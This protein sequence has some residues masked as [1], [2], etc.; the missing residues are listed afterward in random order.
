MK[1]LRKKYAAEQNKLKNGQKLEITNALYIGNI[2]FTK[3]KS[4][5]LI[6]A[7]GYI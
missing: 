7:K 6:V 4:N 1:S 5:M 2:H 3:N